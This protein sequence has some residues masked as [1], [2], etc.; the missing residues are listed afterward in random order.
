VLSTQLL[1]R[2]LIATP[3]PHDPRPSH[4]GLRTAID[5]V[6]QP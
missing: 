2:T 4:L 5:L 1:H 3:P 6:P